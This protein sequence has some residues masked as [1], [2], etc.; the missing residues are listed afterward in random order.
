MSKG[1]ILVTGAG[2]ALGRAIAAQAVSRA[3][4]YGIFTLRD[5]T[6]STSVRALSG[7]LQAAAPSQGP[8][9]HG[10]GA[11]QA[12]ELASLDLSNLS[13]VRTFAASV[14]RRVAS[15]EL[16]PIRALVLNA[17]YQE[18]FTLSK[19]ADGFDMTFQVNYLGHFLL[20][21]L[22]LPSLDKING[23]VLTIGSCM[24][25]YVSAKTLYS[26]PDTFPTSQTR[27]DGAAQLTYHP[28]LTTHAL[29]QAYSPMNIAPCS[30]PGSRPSH[31]AN[32]APRRPTN[33]PRL[34]SDDMAR[35]SFARSASC[36]YAAQI[37]GPRLIHEEL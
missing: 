20:T 11:S 37:P 17:G 3:S 34:D 23:R 33:R 9:A 30:A 16:A 1:T 36:E 13:R 26:L 25:E 21:Q 31:V 22:L 27:T 14:N 29:H 15:G 5:S 7:A 10:P 2:G 6:S 28:A 19:T 12:Y 35:P 18:H 32:G 24:H 4:D 8:E